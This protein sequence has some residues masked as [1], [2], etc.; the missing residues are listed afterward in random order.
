MDPTS[1]AQ[2]RLQ[3]HQFYEDFKTKATPQE[4]CGVGFLLTKRSEG[5]FILTGL[6][7]IEHVAKYKWSTLA[8]RQTVKVC[9][10]KTV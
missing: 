10:K 3:A 1:T 9:K 6:Q 2:I 8:D 4:L 7:L 5:P